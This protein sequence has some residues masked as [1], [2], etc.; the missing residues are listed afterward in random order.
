[1]IYVAPIIGR[2]RGQVNS[3]GQ[4]VGC[5]LGWFLQVGGLTCKGLD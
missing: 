3:S 4:L 1:M 2:F 5:F